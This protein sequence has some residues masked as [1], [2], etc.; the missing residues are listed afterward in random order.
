MVHGRYILLQSL[1]RS[2]NDRVNGAFSKLITFFGSQGFPWATTKACIFLHE[3]LL[4]MAA[5]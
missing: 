1:L 5:Q 3:P 4:P 2:H